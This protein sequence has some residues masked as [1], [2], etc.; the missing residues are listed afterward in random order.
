[1]EKWIGSGMMKWKVPAA[2]ED[3]STENRKKKGE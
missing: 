1:M 2:R 3:C